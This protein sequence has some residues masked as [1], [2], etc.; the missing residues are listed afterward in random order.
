MSEKQ[1]IIKR[2]FWDSKARRLTLSPDHIEFEDKAVGEDKPVRL[3]K[4]QIKEFRYGVVWLRGFY[5]YV[6]R[7]YQIFVRTHEGEELKIDFLT[8]YGFRK[9]ELNATYTGVLNT[10]LDL[11]FGDISHF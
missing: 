3:L 2:N 11:Y 4:E 5:F 10:M 1:F 6:G 7:Q 8:Y 9:K